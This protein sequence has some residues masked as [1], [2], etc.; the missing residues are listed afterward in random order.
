MRTNEWVLHPSDGLVYRIVNVTP[1]IQLGQAPWRWSLEWSAD[2]EP[3]SKALKPHPLDRIYVADDNISEV[4]D[5]AFNDW[6]HLSAFAAELGELLECE[7]A[8]IVR[9]I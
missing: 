8:T 1:A 2:Y 5:S 4:E 7:P 3:A 9:A 6:Q